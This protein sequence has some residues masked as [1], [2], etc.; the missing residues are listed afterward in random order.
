M[1][2]WTM[3]EPRKGHTGATHF[4]CIFYWP[5]PHWNIQNVTIGVWKSF[6]ILCLWCVCTVP[7]WCLHCAYAVL[8]L[9]LWCAR[10]SPSTTLKMRLWHAQLRHRKGLG[11]EDTIRAVNTTGHFP[12]KL[13][14]MAYETATKRQ[15]IGAQNRCNIIKVCDILPNILHDILH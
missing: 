6:A 1:H 11:A 12:F 3:Q 10:R 14:L 13:P 7:V 5:C 2:V 9:C 4:P 15:Q 8:A